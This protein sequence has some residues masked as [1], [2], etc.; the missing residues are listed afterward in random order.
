MQFMD[1][2]K[3]GCV[4]KITNKITGQYYIGKKAYHTYPKFEKYWSSCAELKEDVKYYGGKFFIKEIL[5][6]CSNSY[7]LSYWELY[8]LITHNWEDKNC[9]NKN[10]GGKYFKSKLFGDESGDE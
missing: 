4:Y 5:K 1:K 3:Y 7:S 2:T 9:Y 10:I 8:Y 6:E